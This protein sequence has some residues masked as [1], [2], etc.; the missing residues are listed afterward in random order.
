MTHPAAVLSG[1]PCKIC[2]KPSSITMLGPPDWHYCPQHSPIFSL[3]D[4]PSTQ[5]LTEARIREIVGE[6]IDRLKDQI[7][8]A[9]GARP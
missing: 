1:P 8:H 6:E 2:G 4:I 9:L 5:M 7:E 3:P